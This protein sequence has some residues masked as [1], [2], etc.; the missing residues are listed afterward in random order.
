MV[1]KAVGVLMTV[2]VFSAMRAHAAFSDDFSN[3]ALS[4]TNWTSVSE[5]VKLQFSNGSCTVINSN[6]QYAGIAAHVFPP[7]ERR[8]TFTLSGKIKLNS[9]DMA[10]GFACCLTLSG[11]GPGY[12]IA[13]RGDK[14]VTVTKVSSSGMG[15]VLL[16][17]QSAYITSGTN[18]LR[19]SKNGNLFNICCNSHF[20]ANFSDNEFNTGDIALLVLAKTTA[21]FDDI[22]MT[23][24]FEECVPATCFVDDFN[25]GVKAGWRV[26]FGDEGAKTRIDANAL[27]IT[28]GANQNL[29]QVV[30][31]PLSQFVMKVV[32]S[33][34]GGNTQKLYGLF[35]CGKAEGGTTISLAGFGINGARSFGA[36][37]FSAGQNITLTPSSRIR[38]APYISS[39]GDTT[40]YKDTLEVIKRQ[41][42]PEYL[43]IVNGDTLTRF[44]GVNF[45]ITG[46]GVFCLDNLDVV[47]DDFVA[48]EGATGECPV[49][50]I[51]LLR[52]RGGSV[53]P[54]K[55]VDIRIFDLSGR[56]IP[57]DD[58]M[59][60]CAGAAGVS[61][62]RNEASPT[63]RLRY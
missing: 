60:R 6:T 4:N 38:G 7:E 63:Y 12:Y 34:H 51:I 15:T 41:G 59:K 27:R 22:V 36:F 44:T 45:G 30:D 13:F 61:V 39:T 55:S 33:L 24:S 48:A 52:A 29:Y 11:A 3:E 14:T 10:A 28:T 25:S 50:R 19:V 54:P 18:E 21:V 31:L 2:L 9:A 5:G 23:D 47:F 35:F 16:S 17:T 40:F 58:R 37:T 43:F 56:L 53:S 42:S 32:V 57:G 46:A 26:L 1:N 8:S 62:R 20:V 49:R